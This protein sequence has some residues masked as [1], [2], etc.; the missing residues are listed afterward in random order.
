MCLHLFFLW[1]KYGNCIFLMM[2]IKLSVAIVFVMMMLNTK[3]HFI[4]ITS[5]DNKK[6]EQK[7]NRKCVLATKMLFY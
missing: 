1:K 7:E 2:L 4:S 5:S 6:L 3:N